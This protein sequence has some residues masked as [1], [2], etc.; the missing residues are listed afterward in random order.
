V[1]DLEAAFELAA[2][3]ATPS[4][5]AAAAESAVAPWEETAAPAPAEPAPRV[6]ELTD[7]KAIQLYNAYLVLE[8]PEGILV[9][10]QHALHERILFEQF[11]RRLL[12]GSLET[13]RLLIP[14]MVELTREQAALAL[15]HRDALAE[16]GL[17]I[18]DF[19]GGTL[20]LQGYPAILGQ[21]DPQDLL[22]SVIDHL[23]AKD[24]LPTR[25]A[26]FNDLLSLMACHSA[27]RAGDPLTPEQIVALLAQ[28]Q[29]AEDTH[30]CPHGRPTQLLFTRRDLDRQ[31]GRI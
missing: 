31:F 17:L 25:E 24:R 13:Q 21:R 3:L 9:I 10:D 5:R 12:E 28:R 22:K 29:L 19:G 23:C 30:H 1:A 6:N 20:L 27:V 16:L 18:E 8:T 11:K 14:E 4:P 7:L 2:P 15:E 26:L